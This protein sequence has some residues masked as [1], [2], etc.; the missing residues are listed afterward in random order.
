MNTWTNL[1]FPPRSDFTDALFQPLYIEPVVGSG[2]RLCFGVVLKFG[3]RVE[4]V[5]VPAATRLTK[6]YGS[7]AKALEFAMTYV[8]ESLERSIAEG[9]FES[10][11][12]SPLP[13]EGVFLTKT[14]FTAARS[15]DECVTVALSQV[16][17]LYLLPKGRGAQSDDL[18][19]SRQARTTVSR[20]ERVVSEHV[21]RERPSLVSYFHKEFKVSKQARPTKVTFFSPRLV[22]NLGLLVPND[23]KALVDVAKA[24]ILDL[25]KLREGAAIDAV[26]QPFPANFALYVQ[27]ATR[28]DFQFDEKQIDAVDE[29]TE[30]LRVISQRS[31]IEF[32]PFGTSKEIVGEILELV[33]A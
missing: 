20:L 30:E 31:S 13:V 32:K 25:E 6:L 1:I 7:A 26:D 21:M 24:R 28:Y 29:A 11:I 18:T 22:A 33:P 3:D 23:M 8:C 17:S 2:E 19:K 16:A 15:F 27:R 12:S 14:R 5:R 9:N 10:A 4:V